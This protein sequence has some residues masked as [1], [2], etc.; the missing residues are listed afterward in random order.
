MLDVQWQ[1]E[2]G[3]QVI[4]TLEKD[5]QAITTTA[6]IPNNGSYRWQLDPKLDKGKGYRLVFTNV[7]NK[8]KTVKS[9][10]FTVQPKMGAG[11]KILPFIVIGGVAAILFFGAQDAETPTQG[12]PVPIKP[13][14]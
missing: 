6:P 14:N 2:T 8:A 7:A 5:G 13:G 1:S 10:L 11:L 3:G 4:L 9:E 12:I